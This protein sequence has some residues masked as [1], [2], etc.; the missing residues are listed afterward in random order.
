MKINVKGHIRDLLA[1]RRLVPTR[2][3]RI[4]KAS[5]QPLTPSPVNR[6]AGQLHPKRQ[7]LYIADVRD[8]TRT[9]R[10][11]RLI[12]DPDLDTM[13]LAYFRAG[14]YLSLKIEVDGSGITRPYSISSAPYEALGVDGFYEITIRRIDDGFFTPYLWDNWSVGTRIQSSGPCGEFYYEPIRDARKIIGLAGG[15]GITPFCSMAKE[16]VL[17]D[18]HAELLLLYGSSDKDD[19][20]YYDVLKELEEEAPDKLRVVHVLSCDEVPLPDCEQGFITADLIGK[21]ADVGNSSFFICGPQSMYEFVMGELATLD[22]PF[23][24]I[25]REVFGEATDIVD[26]PGFPQGIAQKRFQLKVH[27]GSVTA[28]ISGRATETVLVAMERAGLAPPSECRSGECGVCR[29]LLIAGDVYVHPDCDG[30]RAFN[31]MC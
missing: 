15:M 19:I 20:V 9:S 24:R 14:Q 13:E 4:A 30:R 6:L 10:T 11:F 16:I 1:F 3:K 2:R 26:A 8:E 18:M 12:P 21:Y 5:P 28:E 27:V 25:R 7:N 22:L 17:G 29:S 31:G 23:K